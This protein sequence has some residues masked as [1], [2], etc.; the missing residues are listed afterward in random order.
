MADG[1]RRPLLNMG[2]LIMHIHPFPLKMQHLP[3][4][5]V[6]IGQ[7][8][9]EVDCYWLFPSLVYIFP[10]ARISL[11]H[12]VLLGDR[13]VPAAAA[14]REGGLSIEILVLVHNL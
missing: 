9:G 2:A 14:D 13:K 6:P 10:R 8:I 1:R 7:L 12:L 4:F 3:R 11:R 5:I